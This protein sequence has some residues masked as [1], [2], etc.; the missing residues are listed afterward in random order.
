M[1]FASLYEIISGMRIV[2]YKLINHGHTHAVE[3][4]NLAQE[5]LYVLASDPM[6]APLEDKAIV[7]EVY[8][9]LFTPSSFSLPIQHLFLTASSE[10][11]EV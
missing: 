2:T 4:S 9:L 1:Y 5:L 7:S 8:S 6:V 10:Y 3:E 11:G